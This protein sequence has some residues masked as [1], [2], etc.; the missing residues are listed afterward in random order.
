MSHHI[1]LAI[2]VGGASRR[3]GTSQDKGLLSVHGEALVYRLIRKLSFLFQEIL[4]ICSSET[5]KQKYDFVLGMTPQIIVD[6][7]GSD[8]AAYYGLCAALKQS[9]TEK[10]LVIPVDAQGVDPGVIKK[11]LLS[12]S[13]P[14]A[15]ENT[16]FPSVWLKQHLSFVIPSTK[17]EESLSIL[18]LLKK[19]STTWIRPTECEDI[20]LKMNLNTREDV[21]NYFGEP[22]CDSWGRQLNY[23]RLSLTE[24]C[25]MACQ[26]CLP[27]GFHQSTHEQML[28]QTAQVILKAFRKLG[29]EKVRFTG[30]EPTLHPGLLYLISDARSL[31]Y[32][33]ISLT[34][35]GSF[36]QDLTS[37]IEAGLT[38]INISLD[39]LDPTTFQKLTGSHYL[40]KILGLI[41]EALEKGLNV[42]L[43]TVLLQ[44]RRKKGEC[45]YCEWAIFKMVN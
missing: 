9:S 39:T 11:L 33:T 14:V 36:I 6:E 32:E 34:T 31:G 5:Q 2:L 7:S 43:N 16:P 20:L 35:N 38:H 17:C 42:K 25:N 19:L 29:F 23:L 28:T 40:S 8:R 3:M 45:Q 37:L 22:L 10:V 44:N 15:Y 41:D 4:I 30:G 13:F 27:K 18:D 24:S 12:P 1:T 21:R 26:Y